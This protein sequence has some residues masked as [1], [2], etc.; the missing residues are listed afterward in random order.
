[1]L[2]D[3]E[4]TERFHRRLAGRPGMAYALG[5]MYSW[6]MTMAHDHAATCT[7]QECETCGEFVA[8][9]SLFAAVSRDLPK[10]RGVVERLARL[11]RGPR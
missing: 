6:T 4:L 11:P 3:P 7:A 8:A 5:W 9:L 10:S 2:P 1:M